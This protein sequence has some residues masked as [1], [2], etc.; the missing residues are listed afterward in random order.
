MA[1]NFLDLLARDAGSGPLWAIESE[2][3]DCTFVAWEEGK[4][5]V[6]H[7]NTEVDVVML[8]V[9]GQGEARVNADIIGL[10]PGTVI[11]IPKGAERAVKASSRLSYLNIHKRRK[12]LMPGDLKIRPR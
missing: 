3:L 12:R 1:A 4:G 2:D 7:V 6:S 10:S 11:L 8:V 5:V 9:S